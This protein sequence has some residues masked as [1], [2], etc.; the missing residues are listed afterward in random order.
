VIDGSSERCSA[1]VHQLPLV[2]V[3]GSLDLRDLRAAGLRATAPRVTVPTIVRD[4]GHL[5]VEEI[6]SLARDRLRAGLTQAIYDV[7]FAL[8]RAGL[9][10]RIQPVGSPVRF[11]SRVGD[12]HDHLICR[13][14]RIVLDVDCAVG[15][16]PCLERPVAA[17]WAVD[18]A[19]IIYW[20]LCAACRAVA[21][22]AASGHSPHEESESKP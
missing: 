14:Y 9:V 21:L 5:A 20:G 10:R 7:R 8:T 16:A 15:H 2:S 6:A 22:K 4:G 12:S 18:E 19:E 17:G 13:A 3:P 11:E 1:G